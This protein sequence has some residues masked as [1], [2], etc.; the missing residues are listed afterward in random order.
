MNY[1]LYTAILVFIELVIMLVVLL[2]KGYFEQK[3]KLLADTEHA[4]ELTDITESVKHDYTKKDI[5]YGSKNEY[6]KERYYNLYSELYAVISQSEF[7][8]YFYSVYSTPNA[9]ITD[10]TRIPF[11]EH[12]SERKTDRISFKDGV[13]STSS[14]TIPTNQDI[15][16]FNKEYIYKLILR[17]S[18]YASQALLSLGLA[19]RFVH[20][21]YLKDLEKERIKQGMNNEEV[22]IIHKI[23]Q[24]VIKE[25]NWLR[26][27]IGL[28]YNNE[29]M[30]SMEFDHAI[31]KSDIL[32]LLD[33]DKLQEDTHE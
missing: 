23:V 6:F 5:Q 18:N 1:Y 19:Y 24:V 12:N 33:S 29:E 3:G 22:K 32:P 16:D 11:I 27:E 13:S 7:Q 31:F 28:S 25:Y 14:E 4:K 2:L 26:K 20:R 8:R 17:N 15:T 21:Y 10:T 9:D 30:L